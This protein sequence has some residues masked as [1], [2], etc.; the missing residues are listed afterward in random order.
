MDIRCGRIK[1]GLDPQ[2]PVGFL[3]FAEFS[4]NLPCR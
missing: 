3:G 4:L 1:A 2:R